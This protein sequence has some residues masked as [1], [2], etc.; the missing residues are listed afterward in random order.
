M[1][2]SFLLASGRVSWANPSRMLGK[3]EKNTGGLKGFLLTMGTC[4]AVLSAP[5]CATRTKRDADQ[6]QVRYQLAVGYFENR[7]VE[8]AVDE[9]QKAIAAD[10]QNADLQYLLGR[11]VRDAGEALSHFEQ[12]TKGANPSVFGSYALA[13]QHTAAGRFDQAIPHAEKVSNA[14]P[15]AAR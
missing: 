13:Y 12:A 6:S 1:P 14:R 11:V 3:G 2:A 4:I 5:G 7:R 15:D 10:P 8:A 9:L